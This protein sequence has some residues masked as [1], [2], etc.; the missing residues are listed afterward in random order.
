MVTG[1]YIPQA[2][3]LVWLEFDPQAG[4]EQAGRRPGLVLS[5]AAYNGKTGLMIV[6]P[7]TNQAKGYPF[8]V[9]LPQGLNIQGVVLADHLKNLDWRARRAQSAG[10]AP[11][12]V[13]ADVLAKAAALLNL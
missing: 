9:R 10:Q 4:R 12:E 8:E 7:I 5:P 3:D 13:L 11:P 6:C 1:T 2:G